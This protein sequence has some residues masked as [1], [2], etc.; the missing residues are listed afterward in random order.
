MAIYA[1]GLRDRKQRP[2]TKGKRNSVVILSLT[3][4]VD[5]FTVLVVFLLQNYQVQEIEF[6]DRI[7]MPE[8][9]A[10]RQL[11][12]S[13][14]VSVS[15]EDITVDAQK[16]VDIDS[17]REQE[18]WLID[19]LYQQ[20][21]ENIQTAKDEVRAGLRLR[22]QETVVDEE[23]FTEIL[24]LMDEEITRLTVQADKNLDFLTIKKV[25]Y[26]IT[27]AGATEINFAV[28]EVPKTNR[29][30]QTSSDL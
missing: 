7:E 18:S 14:V 29:E 9:Q 8:A 12:K 17:V 19:G 25:L 27:E 10:V 30:E 15:L 2:R 6:E 22:L 16:I 13:R 1:P 11:L 3:A 5:M 24:E 20:V 21:Q 23:R 26:T 4:M 28:F